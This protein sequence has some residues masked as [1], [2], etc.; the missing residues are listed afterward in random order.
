MNASFQYSCQAKLRII[1]SFNVSIKFEL[2]FL[3]Y[4]IFRFVLKHLNLNLKL[5]VSIL[6]IHLNVAEK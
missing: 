2:N 4:W 6:R 5:E 3:F 1:A